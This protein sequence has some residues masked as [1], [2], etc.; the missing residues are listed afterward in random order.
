MRPT[1]LVFTYQYNTMARPKLDAVRRTYHD[2]RD[3]DAMPPTVIKWWNVA[4][5]TKREAKTLG[6]S[7]AAQEGA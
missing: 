4:A 6:K 7:L 1:Y 2:R 5:T 3:L